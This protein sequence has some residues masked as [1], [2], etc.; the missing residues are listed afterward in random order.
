MY[1]I[2]K[3]WI[4]SYRDLPFKSYE[5]RSVFRAE[6]ENAVFPLFRCNE[7]YWLEAHDV[8]RTYEEADAQVK[9][10][11]QIYD[12]VVWKDL[13]IPFILL[14]RPE[15]DKFLGADYTCAYDAPLPDGRVLQIGTT[16]N[17]GQNFS[18]AFGIMFLDEDEKKKYAY[19]TSYGPGTCRILGEM[20]AVQSDNNGLV[21]PFIAAP[22][23]FV[24]IPILGKNNE[25]IIRLAGKIKKELK[26]YSVEIDDR[27]EYSAGWK[28]NEWELKGAPFRI[29]IGSKEL[30][31][32][33]VTIVDR[34]KRNKTSVKMKELNKKIKDLIQKYD[35]ELKEKALKALKLS[36]AS[37]KADVLKKNK[38]GVHLIEIPFCNKQSCA[39]KLREESNI[40]VRGVALFKHEEKSVV[41]CEEKARQRAKGKKCAICNNNAELMSYVAKQY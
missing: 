36:K 40:R 27:E 3:Y 8:Q 10:D 25:K 23:Q 12:K 30:T 29:E 14:K 18:K 33:K 26:D 34:I 6:P 41:E 11:M 21:L 32:E 16:H 1:S 38:T 22:T 17:L 9:Q 7:F 39:D 15:W 13:S 19:Q 5:T 24:I 20:I 4:R 28:F 31:T 35:K 2:F 37:T